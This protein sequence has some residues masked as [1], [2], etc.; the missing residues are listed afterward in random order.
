MRPGRGQMSCSR[1]TSSSPAAFFFF[2]S[3]SS[4]S[5]PGVDGWRRAI[6]SADQRRVDSGLAGSVGRSARV[7]NNWLTTTNG[8]DGGGQGQAQTR[9]MDVMMVRLRRD[10]WT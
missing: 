3:S 7:I 4:L 2:V 8:R 10:Q 6:L 1:P 9:L 5:L